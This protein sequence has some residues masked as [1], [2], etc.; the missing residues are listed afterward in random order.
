M[1]YEQ[2]EEFLTNDLSRK[3]LQVCIGSQHF[4]KRT[5]Q[6]SPFARL[7]TALEEIFQPHSTPHY[8]TD[9][10]FE[11]VQSGPSSFL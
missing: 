5:S 11:T 8:N 1:N 7:V 9:V 10:V 4:E 2:E 3:L 6:L